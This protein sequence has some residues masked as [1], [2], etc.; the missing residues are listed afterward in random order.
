MLRTAELR[1]D[2]VR[3]WDSGNTP[4]G[5][6][7]IEL[8]SRGIP[9]GAHVLGVRVEV[10][11]RDN[12]K[13]GYLSEQSFSISLPEGK[14][15]RVEI[16][17]DEDGYPPSYNPDI[18]VEID[19]Y[20]SE[21]LEGSE[22]NRYVDMPVLLVHRFDARRFDPAK[23]QKLNVFDAPLLHGRLLPGAGTVPRSTTLTPAP[24]R[25]MPSWRGMCRSEWARTPPNWGRER[26]ALRP[27]GSTTG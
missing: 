7:P 13:L 1:L 6:K 2:G 21:P 16:T 18:E 3:I 17:I 11:L 14:K 12:P 27:A 25:F 19:D 26:S 4:P 5:D 8:A 22:V 20:C 23:L 9:A 15:T 10:R 24:T